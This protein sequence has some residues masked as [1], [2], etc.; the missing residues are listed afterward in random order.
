MNSLT[1]IEAPGLL[2]LSFSATTDGFILHG[3]Q[4][5][6]LSRRTPPSAGEGMVFQLRET[7]ST[8]GKTCAD[9]P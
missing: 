7:V 3:R 8:L 2:L 6:Y 9:S 1:H 5:L 4:D